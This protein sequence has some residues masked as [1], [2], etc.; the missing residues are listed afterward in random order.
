M[1]LSTICFCGRRLILKG[2]S[3][4]FCK[5]SLFT[6]NDS[7]V[8]GGGLYAEDC[9]MTISDCIFKQNTASNGARLELKGCENSVIANSQFIDNDASNNGGG[10]YNDDSSPLVYNTVFYKNNAKL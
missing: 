6:E 4:I 7:V 3:N 1:Y 9:D 2:I 10:L 5:F 8:N